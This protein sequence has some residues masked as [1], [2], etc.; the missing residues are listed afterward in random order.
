ELVSLRPDEVSE[1]ILFPRANKG[2]QIRLIRT[3]E[4]AWDVE[5][6]GKRFP[7]ETSSVQSMLTTLQNLEATN[8]VSRSEEKWNE[9]EVSDSLATR[10]QAFQSGKKIAD[11]YIGKF[12]FSQPRQM[13]TYVRPADAKNTYATEGFLG[14]TFNR[15]ANDFRS[16]TLIDASTDNWTQLLYTHPDH[17]SYTL[18]KQGNQ[19]KIGDMDADSATVATY[20]N[21]LKNLRS[22]NLSDR[23]EKGSPEYRLKI[24]GNNM[25][26]AIQIEAFGTGSDILLQSSLNK[27]AL[28]R[29]SSV[30]AKIFVPKEHFIR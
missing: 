11:L 7:A 18:Q 3:G 26:E 9:F 12:R 22:Y 17:G 25:P 5:S 1:L 23:E 10:V 4:N 6:E 27:G 8:L 14:M 28:F 20:L 15:S 16:K 24:E 19:W 2:T 30:V 21:S 29:D 13:A